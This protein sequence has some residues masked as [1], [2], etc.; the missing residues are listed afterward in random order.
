MSNFKKM[1]PLLFIE[2]YLSLTVLLLIIGPWDFEITNPVKLYG[3]LFVYQIL[4]AVG[5]FIAMKYINVKKNV[6]FCNEV[7]NIKL[8]KILMPIYFVILLIDITRSFGLSSISLTGIIERLIY[9]IQNPALSYY[10]KFDVTQ[11]NIFLGKF[12]TILMFIGSPISYLLLSLLILYFKK[13]NL[14][15]K[16]F[17]VI[18]ISMYLIRY[19]ATGTN[20][21]VFD[22]IIILI[23]VVFLSVL[24]K[25]NEEKVEN[26]FLRK[27]TKKYVTILLL[28]IAAATFFNYMIGSRSFGVNFSKDTKIGE[29]VPLKEKS[30]LL[31]VLPD[32]LDKPAVLLSSYLTQGYYGL[33]LAM[34]VPVTPMFGVGSSMFLVDQISERIDIDKFTVQKKAEKKFGWN[35]RVQW[36]SMYSWIANDV[37]FIGVG[38]FMAVLG[39]A[40]GLVYKDIMVNNNLIAKVLFTFLMIQFFFVPA[41]NQ[42]TVNMNSYSSTVFTVFLWII[43]KKGLFITKWIKK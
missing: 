13:F 1:A 27:N 31:D 33:S 32:P 38:I 25:K 12:G 4:L 21:G 2:F 9:G 43:S 20:K 41:N 42:L 10:A 17:T 36:S 35:S 24:Q 8:I 15:Y 14:K 37:G 19:I 6:A 29:M 39:M 3:S 26:D 16:I 22:I 34:Q 28:F 11:S 7:K 30:L 18:I 40:F 23:S 5:Y